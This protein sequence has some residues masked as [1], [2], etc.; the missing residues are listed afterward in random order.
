VANLKVSIVVRCKIDG[1][2]AWVPTNGKADPSG[3]TY[4]LRYCEGSKAKF[5]KAGDTYADSRA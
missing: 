4:Y 2:R 3:G 5:A 1:K